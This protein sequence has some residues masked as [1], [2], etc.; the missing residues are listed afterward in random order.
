[1][2]ARPFFQDKISIVRTEQRNDG[3]RESIAEENLLRRRCREKSAAKA[4]QGEICAKAIEAGCEMVHMI[5]IAKNDYE[6]VIF[7]LDG[8]LMD[9][10]WV[11]GKIDVE[12]LAGHGVP[13]PGDL[14][15]MIGGI[16]IVE[17]AE[18]FQ[19]EFGIKD[20]AEKMIDDWNRMAWDKYSHEVKPKAGALPFVE[21]CHQHGIKLGVA[22][23]NSRE[24]IDVAIAQNGMKEDFDVV[25]TGSEV[26]KGKPNPDIY[27][28]AAKELGV[29][30][31]KCLVFEDLVDGITAATRAGMTCIAVDDALTASDREEKVALADGMIT[32]F[33][34]L[35]YGE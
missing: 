32:D 23:S 19:R 24:L 25:L 4:L 2:N 30:P 12:Y 27:L 26:L 34:E 20:S 5:K 3:R 35:S 31:S 16:S 17:V 1:M 7:D 9:S 13:Y 28:L 33:T 21:W 8:S 29:D 11:W 6:A 22:S 14:Q 15:K 18:L 10:M